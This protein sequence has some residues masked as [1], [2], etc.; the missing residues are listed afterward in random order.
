MSLRLQVQIDAAELEA[1]VSE[2]LALL[3]RLPQGV[4]NGLLERFSNLVDLDIQL[5]RAQVLSATGTY[6]TTL[7]HV[8]RPSCLLLDELS[9]AAVRALDVG[10][11]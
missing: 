5:G 3:E 7:L 1:K 11:P 6:G 2:T 10:S 4:R 9:A 8:F